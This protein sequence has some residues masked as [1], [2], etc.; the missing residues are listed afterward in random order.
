MF[1]EFARYLFSPSIVP[2]SDDHDIY[3]YLM[4]LA[5]GLAGSGDPPI[6][7]KHPAMSRATDLEAER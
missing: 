7:R 1:I 3:L 4:I 2:S 6:R 5:A